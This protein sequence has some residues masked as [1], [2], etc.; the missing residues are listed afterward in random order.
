MQLTVSQWGIT[1]TGGL[2]NTLQVQKGQQA[3]KAVTMTLSPKL[4]PD[5]LVGI[6][7]RHWNEYNKNEQ[8]S[9]NQYG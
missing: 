8:N 6:N 1:K 2:S 3:E 7:W 5:V 4:M 9:V